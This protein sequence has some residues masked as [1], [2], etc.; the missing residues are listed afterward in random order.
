[1]LGNEMMATHVTFRILNTDF[2]LRK[3]SIVQNAPL[4]KQCLS[5]SYYFITPPL[6]L[7][8]GTERSVALFS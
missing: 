7:I 8:L 2:P 5:H 4:E 3:K 1:M 6:L